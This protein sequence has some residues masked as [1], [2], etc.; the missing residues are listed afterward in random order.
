MRLNEVVNMKLN[1]MHITGITKIV[2]SQE[3]KPNTVWEL[4]I[5]KMWYRKNPEIPR[6]A[7]T[8]LTHENRVR[9]IKYAAA[10]P[11]KYHVWICKDTVNIKILPVPEKKSSPR[12]VWVIVPPPDERI[13]NGNTFEMIRGFI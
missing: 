10:H 9:F 2:V 11:D 3:G 4:L 5:D 13:K 6:M 1:G 8:K 7:W 12:I